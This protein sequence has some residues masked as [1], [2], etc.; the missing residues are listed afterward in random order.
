MNASWCDDS[1]AQRAA[2]T[3]FV[4]GLGTTATAGDVVRHVERASGRRPLDVFLNRR[5]NGTLAGFGFVEM[6][7]ED[8][9]ARVVAAGLPP[10]AGRP[11]IVKRRR[12][13]PHRD[14][15]PAPTP[16]ARLPA[17]VFI[18]NVPAAASDSDVELHVAAVAPVVTVGLPRARDGS[19]IGVAF[20]VLADAADA[21][22]VV[23][24]LDGQPFQGR[25]LRVTFARG[26][27]GA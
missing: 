18:G 27:A 8:D 20:V 15:P 9:A 10:L 26:T 24:A 5:A 4:G 11:L 12:R 1:R 25:A 14:E 19:G 7:S 16:T 3:V 13:R 17:H 22:R 2:R 23:A 21:A 6:R